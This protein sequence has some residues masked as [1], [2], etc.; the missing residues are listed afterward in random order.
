[1]QPLKTDWDGKPYFPISHIYKE[2]FGGKIIKIPVSVAESC[3]NRLGIKGMKTCIFCDEHGSFAFPENQNLE[4]KT[5][6][7]LHREKMRTRYNSE[8]FL[9]YFQAYTTTLK[10]VQK[11][12]DLFDVALSYPDIKGIVVGTRPDCLSEQLLEVFDHYNKKIFLSVELG[13]QSFDDDQLIWMRRGHTAAQTLKAVDRLAGVPGL[14]QGL[15]LIF[16][17]PTESDKQLIETARLCNSLPIENIKLHNLHVLKGTPLADMY[18]SGEFIP[19][20][21]DEYSR[22]VGVFLDHLRPDIA[23]HRLAA[24]STNWEELIAPT[25]VKY[26]MRTFQGVIDRLHQGGHYQGRLYK[27]VI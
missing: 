7:E 23:I 8:Q 3:P 19:L 17:W 20:E 9:A 21:L 24:L 16:G 11:L 27:G 22:R 4:L 26:K 1:M 25:W 15:H 12:K 5:Q 18:A 6:I 2:R 10:S 13:A 14:K